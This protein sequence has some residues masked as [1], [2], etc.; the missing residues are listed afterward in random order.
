M[1]S[2]TLASIWCRTLHNWSPTGLGSA[3]NAVADNRATAAISFDFIVKGGL[4]NPA[5][6]G[7]AGAPIGDVR[8]V[9]SARNHEMYK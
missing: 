4:M 3:A 1:P 5:Q 8:V 2:D 6:R 9:K 7:G